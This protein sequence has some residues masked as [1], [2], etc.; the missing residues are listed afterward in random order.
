MGEQLNLG[1][2]PTVETPGV[3][4]LSRRSRS[5]KRPKEAHGL[6]VARLDIKEKRKQ[7]RAC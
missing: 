3:M 5:L 6:I 4:G 7:R 1:R 2:K